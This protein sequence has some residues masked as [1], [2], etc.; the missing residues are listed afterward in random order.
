MNITL[1]NLHYEDVPVLRDAIV[2]SISEKLKSIKIYQQPLDDDEDETEI[3]ELIMQGVDEIR[4][5]E[6][7]Y[8]SM[9]GHKL[10]AKHY[11][12]FG[13]DKNKLLETKSWRY[14]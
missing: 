13:F 1:T 6:R 3:N 14:E 12:L 7:M 4:S 10:T 5:L 9:T 2:R 8:E 11:T